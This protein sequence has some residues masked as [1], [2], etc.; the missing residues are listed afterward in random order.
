MKCLHCGNEISNINANYCENCGT[1]LNS[2]IEDQVKNK[3]KIKLIVSIIIFIIIGAIIV[4]GYIAYFNYLS[5]FDSE[6]MNY[7]NGLISNI[8]VIE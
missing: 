5:N 6:N 8:R 3:I 2:N 7:D 1:K 4:I